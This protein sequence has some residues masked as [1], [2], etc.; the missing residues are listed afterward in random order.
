MV[1]YVARMWEKINV[2]RVLVWRLE[3]SNSLTDLGI[4]A[5]IILK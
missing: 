5:R 4:N 3:G 2:Y 1:G